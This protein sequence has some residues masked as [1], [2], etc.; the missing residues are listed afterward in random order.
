[1]YIIR[2][3][4]ERRALPL[5]L[6][7]LAL[8]TAWTIR[9]TQ[10]SAIFEVYQVI[11]SP[12]QLRSTQAERLSDARTLELQARLVELES[13]NQKLQELLGYVGSQYVARQ[14]E[15]ALKASTQQATQ[16]HRVMPQG[17]LGKAIVA[18]VVGRSADHWWQQITLSRGSKAGI[19]V[20][21]IVTAP[22]GLVGRIIS[23][24]PNTSRVLLI[25]DRTSSVGVTISRSRH[26]GFLRGQSASH[27]VMQFFDKVPDVR[28]GDVVATSPYSQIFPSGL[29]V[30]RVEL[31]NLSKT[32][33]PEA[34][35][36][37]S[38][39]IPYLEWVV[40]YPKNQNP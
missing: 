9:Q 10:G 30:G 6:V 4:W 23:V 12:L 13:Q 25:S 24:T 18:A 1:M 19:Q 2:R 8:G 28:R 35:I 16:T 36:S 32:P 29:P 37:L 11:T 20:G 5:V 17:S 26:M 21:F 27:A 38:A 33:A 39:P 3:W 31:V 15:A 40:V 34:V 22:G 7:S 14:G